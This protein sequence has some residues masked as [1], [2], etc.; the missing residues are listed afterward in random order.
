MSELKPALTYDE[1][2]DRLINIHNLLID[3]AEKAM[4][5]IKRVNYYRLCGYPLLS[6][7]SRKLSSTAP[8]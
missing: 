5:I 4:V 3:D 8:T 7:S 2:I 1:Q 6:K